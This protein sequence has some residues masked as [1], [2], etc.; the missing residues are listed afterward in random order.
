MRVIS[1]ERFHL[2]QNVIAGGV[3]FASLVL[4]CLVLARWTWV[5]F[6]PSPEPRTRSASQ[7]LDSVE[8]A[9]RLLGGA[10]SPEVA[11]NP[12][13]STG[14]RLLGIV[15]ATEGHSGYALVQLDTK[16]IIALQQGEEISPG[17]RLVK[18][19]TKHII[20]ERGDIQET[21]TWLDKKTLPGK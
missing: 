16:E 10:L 20:L 17:L 21:L 12:S 8:H 2:T 1:F 5:W 15:A 3:T 4:L 18:V 9:S 13:T 19:E 7:H 14:V 11:V 6:A